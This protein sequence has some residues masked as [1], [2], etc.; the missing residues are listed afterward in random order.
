MYKHYSYLVQ[1]ESEVEVLK[2]FNKGAD[3]SLELMFDL[4]INYTQF[5]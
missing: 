2:F 5:Y 4:P 3:D 1:S